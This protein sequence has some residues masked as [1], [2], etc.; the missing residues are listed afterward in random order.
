MFHHPFIVRVPL[1]RYDGILTP[2]YLALDALKIFFSEVQHTPAQ[3]SL[4]MISHVFGTTS[5]VFERGVAPGFGIP[6]AASI[7]VKIRFFIPFEI[8]CRRSISHSATYGLL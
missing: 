4:M 8:G 3:A 6:L 1:S 7:I 2:Q 5:I